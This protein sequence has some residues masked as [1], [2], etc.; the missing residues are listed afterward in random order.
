[1]LLTMGP[2][3]P[4]QHTSKQGTAWP[5]CQRLPSCACVARSASMQ[6][7]GLEACGCIAAQSFCLIAGE[8]SDKHAPSRALSI[9]SRGRSQAQGLKVAV[10]QCRTQC[11]DARACSF[12]PAAAC[13]TAGPP[14]ATQALSQEHV[15]WLLKACGGGVPSSDVRR[16]ISVLKRDCWGHHLRRRCSSPS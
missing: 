8:V 5:S 14:R 15:Q 1:M 2:R 12:P 6:A 4:T 9:R 11:T 3:R 10:G 13:D 7:T 16:I